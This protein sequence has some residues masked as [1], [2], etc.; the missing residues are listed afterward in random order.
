[1]VYILTMV[2]SLFESISESTFLF[3]CYFHQY[4]F[5]CTSKNLR[6]LGRIDNCSNKLTCYLPE[7]K[8][9]AANLHLCEVNDSFG[10]GFHALKVH[11]LN[12]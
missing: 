3:S 12:C 5:C 6:M 7:R 1:M 11:M 4:L 9:I 10:K 8:E 2:S